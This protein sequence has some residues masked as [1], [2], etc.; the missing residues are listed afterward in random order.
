[1]TWSNQTT[2]LNQMPTKDDWV[3][4]G[5]YVEWEQGSREH[6]ANYK[7]REQQW[8]SDGPHSP[9][10]SS[11]APM[12]AGWTCRWCCHLQG[13]GWSQ[14]GSW[15]SRDSNLSMRSSPLIHSRFQSR[16][17]H[18][19]TKGWVYQTYKIIGWTVDGLLSTL[20]V[21]PAHHQ[22]VYKLINSEN[23]WGRA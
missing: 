7:P 16:S 19:E 23:W 21:Q 10:S 14:L 11:L 17:S 3:G 20:F 4:L 15:Q 2:T 5:G 8:G 9:T 18:L 22:K 6:G 1:M 13:R 12:Q